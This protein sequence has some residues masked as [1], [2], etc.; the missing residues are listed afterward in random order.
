MRILT[1]DTALNKTYVSLSENSTLISSK[2]VES[3]GDTYHSAFLISTI[4]KI[5]RVKKLFMSDINIIGVNIGPGSFT[6]IRSCITVARTIAQQMNIPVFG[7]SSLELLATLNRTENNS[8][9]LLDARKDN[10]YEACF[11]KDKKNIVPIQIRTIKETLENINENNILIA[12]DFMY[13][14]VKDLPNSKILYTQCKD[15]LGANLATLVYKKYTETEDIKDFH[16]AKIKPLYLQ[17]PF[18]TMPKIN[19]I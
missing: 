9:I 2:I 8:T 1:I 15:D 4:A 6:G 16:W 18:I 19:K 7:I 10:C 5:L 13:D 3:E 17:E 14:I 11:D 12:D